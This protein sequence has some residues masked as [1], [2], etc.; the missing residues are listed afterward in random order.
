MERARKISNFFFFSFFFL[1]ILALPFALNHPAVSSISWDTT[2]WSGSV[3]QQWAGEYADFWF[4]LLLGGVPW[5]AFFQVQ[6][7]LFALQNTYEIVDD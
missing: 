2:D 1:Q 6:K 4:L 3:D 7:Q 5:Q